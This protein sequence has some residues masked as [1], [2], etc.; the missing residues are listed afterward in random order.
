MVKRRRI[1]KLVGAFFLGQ[2][3][4]AGTAL[5][6]PGPSALERMTLAAFLDVLLPRDALS[7]SASDLGVHDELW[8]VARS[9][10]RFERLL[11][12][13]CRWLDMTG[14]PP[15]HELPTE[16]QIA[17]IEWMSA[18]DW[19]GVPRRFYE[20]VRQTAVESYYSHPESWRG[21]AIERP[22]QPLGYL[23]PW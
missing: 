11:A 22:P 15:F 20:L 12:L 16:Q 19:N 13:G 2:A 17:L 4:D 14:G 8:D 1:L 21:M 3:F 18:S 9:D 7:G 5:A 23:P 6:A 10:P